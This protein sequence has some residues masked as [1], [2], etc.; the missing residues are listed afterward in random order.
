MKILYICN[1]ISKS[2]GWSVINYYTVKGALDA[3]HEVH[4]LTEINGQNLKLP[5]LKIHNFLFEAGAARKNILGLVKSFFQIQKLLKKNSY[6][7][8]HILVEPYLFYFSVLNHPR[9]VFS[10]V[11]TYAISIFKDSAFKALY[12]KALS[13]VHTFLAIS[14]YTADFFAKTVFSPPSIHVVPLGV[15]MSVF[16]LPYDKNNEKEIAFTFVGHLK[17]R[18]GLGFAIEAINRLK[19]NH[20]AIKL[21]VVGSDKGHYSDNCKSRVKE[22]GLESNVLFLGFK[23]HQEIAELYQKCVGNVLPSVNATDGAFE[24]FGLIHLE[25]NACSI[26]TIGSNN[27]GNESAIKDGQTGF[28]AQQQDFQD[29]SKKMEEV[30]QIYLSGNYEKYAHLCYEHAKTNNWKNYFSSIQQYYS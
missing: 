9:I 2:N 14:Q 27:C 7:I 21:Y 5:G 17:Q 19:Q 23:S 22:L 30:I 6:D 15:D 24:G 3:G 1:E 10:L 29:L 28:L 13:K 12:L 4:V 25:A 8:V 18:K 20:P 26:L 11:G 16:N